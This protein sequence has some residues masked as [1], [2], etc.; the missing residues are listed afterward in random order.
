MAY[1]QFEQFIRNMRRVMA[2]VNTK[3]QRDLTMR[4]RVSR[5]FS[6]TGV[7]EFLG[8]DTTYLT[9]I[10]KDEPHYPEGERIGRERN[11]SPSK[12]LTIRGI[13]ASRPSARHD[14][15]YWRQKGDP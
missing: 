2:Q 5:R 12:I 8:V 14:H 15:L 11:F 9:R 7:A 1:G 4:S 13:L 3:L 10:A 6:Q